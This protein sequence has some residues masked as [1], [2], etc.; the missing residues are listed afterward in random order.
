M[1]GVS[2]NKTIPDVDGIVELT[3]ATSAPKPVE[4]ESDFPMASVLEDEQ[5]AKATEVEE[6]SGFGVDARDQ[7][8]MDY[9]G[10]EWDIS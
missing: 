7:G 5:A 9:E 2:A 4:A 6:S 10:D 1:F 8:D 3:W